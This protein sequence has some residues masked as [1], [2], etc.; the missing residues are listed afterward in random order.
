MTP[1][2]KPSRRGLFGLFAGAAVAPSFPAPA[3]A[4]R[5]ITGNKVEWS[6][7]PSNRYRYT[8]SFEG[9]LPDGAIL[10]FGTPR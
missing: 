8:I 10:H 9:E 6:A 4:E 2:L 5:I 3:A 7:A 1:A